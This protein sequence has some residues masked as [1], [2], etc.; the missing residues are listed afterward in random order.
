MEVIF[1]WHYFLNFFF[2]ILFF[3]HSSYSVLLSL[4]NHTQRSSPL[5]GWPARLSH[6]LWCIRW[7]SA[8]TRTL[9]CRSVVPRQPRIY[10][11]LVKQTQAV[12]R[13]RTMDNIFM[14]YMKVYCTKLSLSLRLI[15]APPERC[16]CPR[17]RLQEF[18]A[19]SAPPPSRRWAPRASRRR[20]RG[21]RRRDSCHER[22][23]W[24][25]SAGPCRRRCSWPGTEARS[26]RRCALAEASPRR[27]PATHRVWSQ[28]LNYNTRF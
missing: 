15:Y 5:R 7:W 16:S 13:H 21:P 27:S 10:V 12:N 19:A 25:W 4:P 23:F 18:W 20:P 22:S 3:N 17:H 26:A 28:C 1:F 9:S 14:K 11:D 2:V 6:T 24:P 8:R